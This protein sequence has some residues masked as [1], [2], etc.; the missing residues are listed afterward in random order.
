MG[1]QHKHFFWILITCFG[2]TLLPILILNLILL[3][4]T[5]GNY[6]KVLLASLWQQQT[7]GIT[8]APTLS[9]I[10]LFKTLRLNDRLPEIDTV[11]FGSSTAMGISQQAFP[12]ALHIYNFAQTG[13]PLST[14][15]GEAEY[16]QQHAP[17]I[18][19]LL[20]PLDW[21]IGFLYEHAAPYAADL[22][23]TTAMRQS[24]SASKQIPLLDKMRDALSYPRIVSLLEISKTILRAE[25]KSATFRGYFLQ[26]SSDDY[27]CPDGTPGKDFD[28][29]HRDT[30]TGFRFDGSATFANSSRVG[31]A[32]SLILLAT[33]S[34]SKYHQNL[35]STQGVPDTLLLQRLAA[36]GERA[37]QQGGSV[38]LFLPP[39]LPGME[40]E[41][42]RHPQLAARLQN[43]KRILD[44][45]ARAQHLA[46]L[47][48]GQAERFGCGA[49]EFIDEH[50][51]AATCYNKIFQPFWRGLLRPDGTIA[52][53]DEGLR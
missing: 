31:N 6:R 17:H 40:A 15:I 12:G 32:R 53:P 11:V 20:I 4:D 39:L 47:D 34:S 36:L 51:A 14:V 2:A 3:N 24:Q 38:V 9:D 41:F 7:R 10:G 42:L 50:H 13:H 30:C 22:S 52:L 33:A 1:K 28:T 25:N 45:W 23:A 35:A 44:E 8:Y 49:E 16:I 21:S 46:I 48:A 27:R 18:K 5:L 43:T 26:D 29:I 37:R 19:R